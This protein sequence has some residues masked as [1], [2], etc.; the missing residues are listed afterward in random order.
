[1]FDASESSGASD[2]VR[3]AAPLTVESCS[4]CRCLLRC[5]CAIDERGSE[6]QTSLE[7]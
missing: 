6:L 5:Y 3:D 4:R 1:M 2:G 7:N